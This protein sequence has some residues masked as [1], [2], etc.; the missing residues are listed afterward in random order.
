MIYLDYAA[1]TPACDAAL[2]AL[3]DTARAFGAN[4]NATHAAGQAAQARLAEVTAH[5]AAL[6]GLQPEELVLTSG[7]T[8]ANNMAILGAARAY[9][10]RGSHL[11]TTPMEH[12]SV[13]GPMMAL[14]AEGFT[15]ELLRVLPDGRVDIAH[16]QSLL[17]PETTLVSLCAVDSE[18]GVIQPLQ[19][20]RQALA[21]YPHCLLHVDATQAVGKLPVALACADLFTLSP[22]KFYGL[23]GCGALAVRGG[24]RLA[25]LWYGGTGATPYR[26]GTPALALA[27]G[28]DA[29]LTEALAQLEPRLAVVRERNAQLRAALA[30]L[31]FVL[32]NSPEAASPFLVNCSVKQGNAQALIEALSQRGVCI[33]SKS[34]CCAKAAPS[35]PVLAMT[36][37]RKRAVNTLRVSLSHLT[38]PQEIDTFVAGLRACAAGLEDC[39]GS[40]TAH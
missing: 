30:A 38:T 1:D 25:P 11:I 16:L 8:E 23:T 22:H 32:L 33:S 10:S 20:V 14:K 17:T 13:T 9:R 29:A 21:P 28:A 35:H 26:S 5:M 4:P 2:Q 6:L 31:P 12:A 7:A 27:A 40:E 39:H 37:D 36:G 3:C 24:L 15:V 34:A 18:V 19:Q